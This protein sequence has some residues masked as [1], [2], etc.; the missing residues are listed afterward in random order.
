MENVEVLKKVVPL[1][2]EGEE[3]I[4]IPKKCKW[5]F[6]FHFSWLFAFI[7]CFLRVLIQND[8]LGILLFPFVVLFFVFI[9]IFCSTVSSFLFHRIVI[10]NQ[11]LIVL[12]LN[13][14]V[15]IKK[16]KIKVITCEYFLDR[17]FVIHTV[18]KAMGH[19]SLL[20]GFYNP[21]EIAQKLG[22]EYK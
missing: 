11:R 17:Y 15:C 21:S 9:L 7:I 8:N 14:T 4:D 19:S 3:V 10:T 12:F 16:E 1:L 5:N 20:I 22:V 2:L 13:K 18:I 6:L